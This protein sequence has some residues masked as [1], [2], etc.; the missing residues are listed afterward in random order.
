M[1]NAKAFESM[2]STPLDIERIM[3]A[4]QETLADRSS[5]IPTSV[6]RVLLA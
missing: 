2:A 6:A 3:I 4:C 5:P 1:F